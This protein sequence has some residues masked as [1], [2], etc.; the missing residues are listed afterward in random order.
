MII[1]KESLAQTVEKISKKTFQAPRKNV[2]EVAK[3]KVSLNRV[4]TN[5]FR[6]CSGDKNC[7]GK[8]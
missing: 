3:E 1:A 8:I 6:K 4:R 2:N 5:M 7:P